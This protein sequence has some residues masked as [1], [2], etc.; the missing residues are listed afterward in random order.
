[1]DDHP[2]ERRYLVIAADGRHTTLGRHTEPDEEEPDTATEGLDSLGLG[3]HV[4]GCPY[5][6]PNCVRSDAP[7]HAPRGHDGHDDVVPAPGRC[8]PS[9]QDDEP[10]PYA[11]YVLHDCETDRHYVGLTR[12]TLAERLVAHHAQA[13]RDRP[14]RPDG[15]MARL[16]EVQ[17]RG[18]PDPFTARV[19]V[20]ART[21]DEACA[22]EALWIER[23][24]AWVPT[25]YNM[26]PG[27]SSVGP[28]GNARALVV[29]DADGKIR[30]HRSIGAA[31]AHR[32]REL[33][34]LGTVL[35][36]LDGR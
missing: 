1:M 2:M 22:L 36:W 18:G 30:T 5:P 29:R 8:G 7:R 11:I 35:A 15:L 23:L 3:D 19:V 25:G 20:H 28:D 12:R 33:Q 34:D 24:R 27:G 10:G 4:P 26:M 21:V 6:Y 32:N 17:S 13:R 31:L 16:R 9:G 14:V